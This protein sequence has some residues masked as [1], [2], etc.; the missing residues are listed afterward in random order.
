MLFK[1][2]VM[3]STKA[4][5]IL[6]GLTF[7]AA[8]EYLFVKS[9]LRT[10]GPLTFCAIEFLI[11]SLV[12]LTFFWRKLRGLTKTATI[13]GSL[14]GL[15][16]AAGISCSTIGLAHTN[17]G[18]AAFII[19]MDSVVIPFFA[20][21][22]FRELPAR[23][24]VIGVIL[25]VVGLSLLTRIATWNLTKSEL[26]LL[27]APISY[28]LY[29]IFNSHFAKE[30]DPLALGLL[31]ILSSTFLLII[32][33]LLVEKPPISFS[34][35]ASISLLYCGIFGVALRYSAQ[36]YAQKFTTASE[37]GLIFTLEPLTTALLGFA[38][39]GEILS[40]KQ[41]LGCIFILIGI[42]TTQWKS[43]KCD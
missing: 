35:Q 12:L 17:T 22:L 42:S 18:P 21:I 15:T 36:A 29:T 32:A 6:V 37:T 1:R 10:M 7:I 31:Q 41:M 33:A 9:A 34:T 30:E 25:A 40:S 19:C 13:R 14:I 38:I 26:W 5:F 2:F 4:N 3:N 23:R 8:S 11:A 39:A 28:A 16:L 43:R 24:V 27:G 20:F